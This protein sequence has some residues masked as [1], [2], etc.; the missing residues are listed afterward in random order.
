MTMIVG[1]LS[2]ILS[3]VAGDLSAKFLHKVQPEKLAAY[4]GIM[5][6][7]HMLT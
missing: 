3:M 6:L 4:G 2:T 5:I 1:F 7:N